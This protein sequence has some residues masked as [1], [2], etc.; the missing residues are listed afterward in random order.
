MTGVQ[1]RLQVKERRDGLRVIDDTYNANP[2]SLHAA[3]DVVAA[4]PGE[5]WLILGDMAEL[6]D[7]AE[8]WHREAAQAAQ[9]AGVSRLYGVGELGTLAARAFGAQGR[10]FA[11]R[12][13]LETAL[14]EAAAPGVTLLVKGSRRM[15]MEHVVEVLLDGANAVGG[16]REDCHPC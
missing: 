1:G 3:L 10:A 14:A 16:P 13:Q 4:M 6:G 7:Q 2:A 12:Q 9:L 15:G 5:R 8:S 11:T